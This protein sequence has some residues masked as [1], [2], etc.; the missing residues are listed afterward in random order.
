MGKRWSL[1]LIVGLAVGA[2]SQEKASAAEERPVVVISVYDRLGV[3]SQLLTKAGE[4]ARHIFRTSGVEV[5]W[6][7]CRPAVNDQRPPFACDGQVSSTH[8]VLTI[9]PEAMARRLPQSHDQF[10]LAIF[11][12]GR[13]SFAYIFYD[14]I[15][16]F[17]P[18]AHLDPA[19]LLGTVASHEIGHLILGPHAH[20]PAG[21]MSPRWGS[22]ELN[23][24]RIGKLLFSREQSDLLR[25]RLQGNSQSV[26]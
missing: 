11:E 15:Q 1:L 9:L 19:E 25:A 7:D 13:G 5:E 18:Y 16:Q 20:S 3:S 2:M 24:L 17:S 21:I 10:G 8:L 14:R 23:Q 4:D 6:L 12:A 26:P 22:D